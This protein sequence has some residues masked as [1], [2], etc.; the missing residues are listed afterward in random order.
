ML[1]RPDDQAARLTR[2]EEC[3]AASNIL[4]TF[5]AALDE[6]E[7]ESVLALFREDAVLSSP[8]REARGHA[9][10]RSFFTEAWAAD[11]SAKRHFVMSPRASWLEPGRVRL[12]A[13]FYFVGRMPDSS[14][15]GWGTYD[16]VVDVTGPEPRFAR[17]RMESHLRTDLVS[18]W[19]AVPAG[20]GR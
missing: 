18:G 13:Y 7:V 14:V 11:P 12:E 15:L 16:D 19:A 4:H 1:T 8:R 2:L 3:A 9:E 6:P 20:A 17:I 5:A 10:I